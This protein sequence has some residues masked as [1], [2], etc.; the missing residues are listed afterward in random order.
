MNSGEL[1]FRNIFLLNINL[2]FKQRAHINFFFNIRQSFFMNSRTI[3]STILSYNMSTNQNV[4]LLT[5][6][7][8]KMY[9][10]FAEAY[11][12]YS[13][14]W[15]SFLSMLH[16]RV[17]IRLFSFFVST[18]NWSLFFFVNG[19]RNNIIRF[20]A[21]YHFRQRFFVIIICV[22]FISLCHYFHQL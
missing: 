4:C 15:T 21:C 20:V 13:Q 17:C 11:S 12:I 19:A 14:F 18:I 16:M 2:G 7:F 8:W 5:T 6:N 22:M 1:R 10:L 9:Y 3:Q